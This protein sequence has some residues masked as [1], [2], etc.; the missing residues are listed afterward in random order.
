MKMSS[1]ARRSIV[2]L[3]LVL[4]APVFAQKNVLQPG[5]A[6][7]ASSANSPS[8]EGVANAIDGKTTKYL[9]F[10][11]R[12]PDPIKPSG[13]VV[14]PSVGVTRVTGMRIESANDAPERDPKTV[15]LEGSN[16]DVADYTVGT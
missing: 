9:N 13:F 12:L 15:T 2:A 5:D 11:S 7:I 14:T 1:L 4:A 16:D 8:S 3:A 6:I 10:D